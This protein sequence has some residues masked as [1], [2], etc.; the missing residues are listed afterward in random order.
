VSAEKCR[1]ALCGN[2][3]ELLGLLQEPAAVI[4][5]NRIMRL[6]GS[7]WRKAKTQMLIECYVGLSK[8]FKSAQPAG[9]SAGRSPGTMLHPMAVG[10]SEGHLAHAPR[11]VGRRLRGSR[12]GSRSRK[13]AHGDLMQ[14][15]HD[16]KA[17]VPEPSLLGRVLTRRML[18]RTIGLAP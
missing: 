3:T 10:R 18:R 6:L 11:P 17:T 12:R 15:L 16:W 4:V 13:K 9:S 14:K 1:T 8:H 5:Q 2:H 7:C